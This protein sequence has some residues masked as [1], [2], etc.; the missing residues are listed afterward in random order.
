[1]QLTASVVPVTFKR[2]DLE[3][4]PNSIE[5]D[6]FF[7][8]ADHSVLDAT[9][10]L[11][12]EKSPRKPTM[13]SLEHHSVKKALKKPHHLKTPYHYYASPLREASFSP[14]KRRKLFSLSGAPEYQPAFIHV[15]PPPP[16]VSK[17]VVPHQDKIPTTGNNTDPFKIPLN[18]AGT[19]LAPPPSVPP[20]Q[21][22]ALATEP[23]IDNAQPALVSSS[24]PATAA[25]DNLPSETIVGGDLQPVDNLGFNLLAT[26]LKIAAKGLCSVLPTAS[27]VVL[28]KDWNVIHPLQD[29]FISL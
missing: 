21:P 20:P 25:I 16:S 22:A 7:A 8:D 5:N 24:V 11:D 17:P 4:V 12:S 23:T 29:S 13:P 6:S 18:P 27:K 3:M 28:T 9:F 2:T 26:K 1:M 14:L 15:S 10:D 19:T